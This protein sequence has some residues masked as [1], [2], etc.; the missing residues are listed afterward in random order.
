MLFRSTFK[1]FLRLRCLRAVFFCLLV[2][3]YP[4]KNH[5]NGAGAFDCAT[6][7][8]QGGC[9]ALSYSP[10]DIC[11]SYIARKKINR[12]L[13]N[14][15]YFAILFSHFVSCILAIASVWQQVIALATHIYSTRISCCAIAFYQTPAQFGL[16]SR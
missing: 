13:L 7:R 1:R 8:V 10:L 14:Q 2:I 4:F 11:L 12:H 5:S 3:V 9:S 16:A 15:S 6:F